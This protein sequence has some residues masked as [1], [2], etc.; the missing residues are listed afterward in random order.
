MGARD[1]A[2][3]ETMSD[4]QLRDEILT[5]MI[6]GHET[7][8][9][10]LIWTW[11]LLSEHPEVRERVE[12]ELDEVLAGRSPSAEDVRALR[13]TGA[14]YSESLRLYPPVWTVGR[15]ALVDHEVGART[16]PAGSIVLLSQH[17]VQHDP[18]WFPDPFVFRPERWLS[19]DAD[20][21]PTFASFPFGAG[22]RVCI[23]QPLAML[24]SVLFIAT[25][26]RR[27][28][29]DLV[30]GHPVEPVPPLMRPANGLPM[31]AQDRTA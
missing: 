5:F 22:P 1:D 2:T 10:S 31:I 19:G 13:F 7:W 14:V 11:F 28:R 23:G 25:I 30:P 21:A 26:A 29:L 27:W 12:A 16:I 24:G 20:R 17:V 4:R 9:N 3:G 6:A 8:T 15:T 18:R